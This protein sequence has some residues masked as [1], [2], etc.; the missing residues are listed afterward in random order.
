MQRFWRI[1][2]EEKAN[3]EHALLHHHEDEYH[4]IRDLLGFYFEEFTNCKLEI[5]ADGDI[6]E[7][8]F[9]PEQEK[10][11]QIITECLKAMAP[12]EVKTNWI[13]HSALPPMSIKAECTRFKGMDREYGLEDIQVYYV[14]D[15]ANHAFNCSLYCE[16]FLNMDANKALEL[17][18]YM[19]MLAIGE[20]ALEGYINSI[21]VA[22]TPKKDQNGCIL[23]DFYDVLTDVAVEGKWPDYQDVYSIYRVFKIN[24]G[25]EES[26]EV[27]HDMKMV[28]SI[29]P[30]LI[31]ETLEGDSF[32][33]Q[34][35]EK[36]GGE[37][38][39]LYYELVHNEVH[40][41][42]Y[43]QRLQSKLNEILYALHIAHSIGGAIGT[44]YAYIDLAIFD[45]PAFLKVLPKI[46]EHLSID[47]RYRSFLD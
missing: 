33:A 7:C 31:A 22:Q 5:E 19:L 39:Y 46:N 10:S 8:T 44:K 41:A 15:E 24:E 42:L 40:D 23:S 3:L 11:I 2:M 45:K 21:E 43:R 18:T 32:I 17:A 6:F 36:L 20:I 9:L 28:M 29:H 26:D 4:E 12:E 38:G 37:Y 47:L 14:L 35:F 1:F 16:A 30:E 34:Q 27:R 13:I 25:K